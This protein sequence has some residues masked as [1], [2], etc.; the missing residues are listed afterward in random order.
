MT[1]ERIPLLSLLPGIPTASGDYYGCGLAG[2]CSLHGDVTRITPCD[3]E[4]PAIMADC[5]D[6][7]VIKAVKRPIAVALLVAHVLKF[8]SGGGQS[9]VRQPPHPFVSTGTLRSP[10]PLPGTYRDQYL[11][12]VQVE[13]IT[14]CVID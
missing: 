12:Y 6:T 14:D 13:I 9:R 8:P 7:H 5:I 3:G 4:I 2:R 1:G 10:L 11:Y